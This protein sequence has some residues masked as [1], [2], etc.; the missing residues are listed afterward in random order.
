MHTI[1]LAIRFSV[2]S[3]PLS[4]LRE[5]NQIWI[6]SSFVVL[7]GPCRFYLSF[8]QQ[9]VRFYNDNCREKGTVAINLNDFH[10]EELI[11]LDDW[12]EKT[13]YLS[14]SK[15]SKSCLLKSYFSN[16]CFYKSISCKEFVNP[17]PYNPDFKQHWRTRL[18]KTLWAKEKMLVTS[19]FSF[20]RCFLSISKGIS[21]FK[22]HLFCCLQT[23]SIWSSLKICHLVKSYSKIF[24]C[25]L[26]ILSCTFHQKTL[27]NCVLHDSVVKQR[28]CNLGKGSTR[29]SI[30]QPF[31]RT[32]FFFSPLFRQCE[33]NTT[34][35]WLHHMV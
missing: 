3:L 8:C 11:F 13:L 31:S 35:D 2:T 6:F 7:F 29:V 14:Q 20:S 27:K 24:M 9:S 16:N 1:W 19:I 28:S 15:S 30:H 10:V 18:L 4:R 26:F 21:V 23:L 32:F 17:L 12:T 34:S 33:C 25:Q 5:S 22:L